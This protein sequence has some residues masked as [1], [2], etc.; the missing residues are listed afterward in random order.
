VEESKAGQSSELQLYE[1]VDN[2]RETIDGLSTHLISNMHRGL[3]QFGSTLKETKKKNNKAIKEVAKTY[4]DSKKKAEKARINCKDEDYD[5]KTLLAVETEKADYQLYQ[6]IVGNTTKKFK[7]ETSEVYTEIDRVLST[8]KSYSSLSEKR[9]P[10]SKLSQPDVTESSL[11]VDDKNLI[12]R[13]KKTKTLM[14]PS[15]SKKDSRK[16]NPLECE[17][18]PEKKVKFDFESESQSVIQV[19]QTKRLK[20][21]TPP[22]SPEESPVKEQISCIIK[23]EDEDGDDEILKILEE[24]AK[25]KFFESNTKFLPEDLRKSIQQERK[26]FME[27]RLTDIYGKS[28]SCAQ[29]QNYVTD[30]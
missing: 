15:P 24:D 30:N 3:K 12:P 29:F 6:L 28:N 17:K 5:E 11:Q 21:P 19:K 25:P 4:K 2:L 18:S 26:S 23:E 27:S 22:K 10:K 14:T 16:V 7:K 13:L 1:Y 9:M 20:P 8:K